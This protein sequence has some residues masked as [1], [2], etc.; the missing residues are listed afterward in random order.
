VPS[1]RITL[2]YGAPSVRYE[3]LDVE[4]PDLR[5]ALRLAAER[6]GDEVAATAELAEI[7][8]QVVPDEREFTP[9]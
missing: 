2:R 8:R 1:Y 3:M 6:M 4:A 5:A 7:R 9:E